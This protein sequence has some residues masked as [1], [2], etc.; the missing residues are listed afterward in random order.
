MQQL[1]EFYSCVTSEIWP[2]PNVVSFHE[3]VHG[4]F[5]HRH[6]ARVPDTA[7]ISR[8]VLKIFLHPQ[9][10][11]CSFQKRHKMQAYLCAHATA[12]MSGHNKKICGVFPILSIATVLMG[13]W[14]W[15]WRQRTSN[16]L[17]PVQRRQWAA[18]AHTPAS[19]QR[20]A[21]DDAGWAVSIAGEKLKGRL[22][23][24]SQEKK[25][26]GDLHAAFLVLCECAAWRVSAACWRWHEGVSG[27]PN[28]R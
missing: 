8:D 17:K 25:T 11:T 14:M 5:D 13:F 16:L 18:H 7:I 24:P 6:I 19:D 20:A 1:Y 26:S 4:V 28:F 10:T 27:I 12:T 15:W 22:N 21:P 23:K 2:Q 9:N 3:S